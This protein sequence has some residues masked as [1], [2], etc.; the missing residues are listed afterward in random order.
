MG[1]CCAFGGRRHEPADLVRAAARLSEGS[2]VREYGD[3]PWLA[4]QL[5]SG[6][7]GMVAVLRASS[8]ADRTAGKPPQQIEFH[9]QMASI[10]TLKAQVEKR[11]SSAK[12]PKRRCSSTRSRCGGSCARPEPDSTSPSS[13]ARCMM[14]LDAAWMR[15]DTVCTFGD[16]RAGVGGSPLAHDVWVDP[17]Q[18]PSPLQAQVMRQTA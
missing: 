9:T 12:E 13:R 8:G 7:E 6:Q 10:A 15:D 16:R 4:I 2:F 18:R 5:P 14:P 3:V 17:L 11:A 1:L